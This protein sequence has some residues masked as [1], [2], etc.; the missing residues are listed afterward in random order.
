M[1]QREN[2][3][4]SCPLWEKMNLTIKEAAEYSNIGENR[5]RELLD[6]PL[7]TFALMVGNK[8]KLVKRR[9]FEKYIDS[10]QCI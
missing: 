10:K 7:C 6:D 5:I 2:I 1:N 9:Q 8:K 4:P 3:V